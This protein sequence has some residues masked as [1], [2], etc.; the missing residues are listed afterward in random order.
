LLVSVTDRGWRGIVRQTYDEPMVSS[1]RG[2]FIVET[3]AAAWSFE[4]GVEGTTVWFEL[5]ADAPAYDEVA[6]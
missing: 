1:G 3:L 5:E 2:L 4:H 6:T